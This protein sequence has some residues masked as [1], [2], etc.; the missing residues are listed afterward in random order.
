MVAVIIVIH[1]GETCAHAAPL[2]E[3]DKAFKR[4]G[5]EVKTTDDVKITAFL[6]SASCCAVL[7]L[8]LRTY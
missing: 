3:T 6:I 7:E 1:D 8:S 2:N 5:I 4:S